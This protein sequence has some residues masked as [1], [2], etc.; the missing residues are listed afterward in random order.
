MAPDAV[1]RSRSMTQDVYERL[2]A[3]ILACRLVPGS[4]LRINELCL[5]LGG[6]SLGAVREAL[7]RLTADG[8]VLS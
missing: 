2:R 4:K 8:F 7:S 6:V 3:D 5:L 1:P